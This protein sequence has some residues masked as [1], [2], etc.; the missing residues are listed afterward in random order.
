MQNLG[1]TAEAK[2]VLNLLQ[3][4]VQYRIPSYQRSYSW[5]VSD[6]TA[7]ID[8]L[9]VGLDEDRPH[10]LGAIVTVKTSVP[11]LFEVVDGQQRLTTLSL[12]LACLRDLTSHLR[13]A[14][15]LQKY[16]SD[17]AREGGWRMTLNQVD[18]P[19]FRSLVQQPEST[20]NAEML[21]C[22]EDEHSLIFDNLLAVRERIQML[23]PVDR[24]ALANF[25]LNNCPMV[26]V[27]VDD[28][29]LGH[30]V[31]QVLNTRGRQPSGV[32]CQVL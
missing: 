12:L 29:D 19:V 27:E 10:F 7:L 21:S 20:L 2:S 30:K 24:V 16:L 23:S 18:A 8:D 1:V 13:K 31:F 22:T 6:A 3:P 9:I 25:V 17:D 4:G 11:G 14:P 26:H 32:V 15:D 28:R 5:Q